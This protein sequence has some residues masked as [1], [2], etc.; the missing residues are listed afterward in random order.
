[1][2]IGGETETGRDQWSLWE[3]LGRIVRVFSNLA[4]VGLAFNKRC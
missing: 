1:M 4:N 3:S 2:E